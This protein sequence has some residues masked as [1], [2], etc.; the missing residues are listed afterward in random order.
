MS[1]VGSQSHRISPNT[2]QIEI[3]PHTCHELKTKRW[4]G[5]ESLQKMLSEYSNRKYP[6]LVLA[7]PS[8]QAGVLGIRQDESLLLWL[9][10]KV[11]TSPVTQ[12]VMS[13][14]YFNLPSKFQ[15]IILSSKCGLRFIMASP[16]ANGF[17]KSRGV[18][19]YLPAAYTY[20]S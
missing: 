15:K 5:T 16:E 17:F 20:L 10:Q 14:A 11:W 18:S 6:G 1:T 9:L 8:I 19:Q 4:N 2:G 13:S 7:F 12:I 3:I